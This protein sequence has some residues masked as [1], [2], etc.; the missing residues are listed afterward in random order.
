MSL[1]TYDPKKV[2]L[3]IGGVPIGG[4]ADGT[5]ILFERT[6]DMF[7]KVVGA[8]GEVSRAKSNDKTGQFTI[9]LLQ[10]S[11]SNDILSGIA[12]LDERLNSGVVPAI[13]KEMNGTTTIFSGTVWVRKKPNIEYSKEVTN[14]E[15]VLDAAESEVFVGG[16][17]GLF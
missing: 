1:K 16:N 11:D 17:T 9:T 12:E 14:R 2:I 4:Y 8:D 10:T 5:F 6:T 3:V 13:L 7:S 15:W